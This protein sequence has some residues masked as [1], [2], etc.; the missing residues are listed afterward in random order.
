[1]KNEFIQ[2]VITQVC[3]RLVDNIFVPVGVSNR[4]VHLS[5]ESVDVLFGKG[6]ALTKMRELKQP[7]QYAAE[8]VV[9]LKGPK[10][11]I[12]K[13]RV[14]GPIRKETQVEIS[15]SDGRSLGI[16]PEVRESGSLE[17]SEGITLIGPAGFQELNQG[18]IA[19]Y[20]HIHMPKALAEEKGIVDGQLVSVRTLGRRSITFHQV[21]VRVS[22]K[23]ALEIHLD[24]EEAN[25]AGIGNNEVLEVIY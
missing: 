17:G 25:A 7:G 10:G 20:R 18:A 19:A 13:V 12:E 1:M 21:L 15:L 14:L 9:I 5:Q 3:Q 24:V 4:H 11:S 22:E 23:Y 16:C 2:A 8:E 6:Y